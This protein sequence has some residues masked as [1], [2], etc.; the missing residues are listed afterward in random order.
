[1]STLAERINNAVIK[2]DWL[3]PSKPAGVKKAVSDLANHWV[4]YWNS[5]ERRLAPPVAQATKL[6]RYA[7]WYARGWAL[8]PAQVRDQLPHPREIDD[9]AW[10][11]LEDQLT[12]TLEGNEAAARAAADAAAKL[13][14]DL[15][16]ASG[17]L[18]KGVV[19][20]GGVATC[21]LLAY[22][23]ARMPRF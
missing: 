2:L 22:A 18:I 3:A 13:A 9:S 19:I 5:S 15:E 20:V 12:Y 1:M 8:V 14:K 7:Q 11:A 17:K 4:A 23:Y 16:A 10:A 21:V 6:S